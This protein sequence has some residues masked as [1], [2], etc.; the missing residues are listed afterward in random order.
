MS[1]NMELA[2]MYNTHGVSEEQEKVAELEL[3]AKLA[4]EHGV[5]LTQMS[6]EDVASLYADVT[7]G[8]SLKLASDHED[9]DDDDEGEEGEKDE[10]KKAFAYFAEKRAEQEKLAEA[11]LMGRIM[12]HSFTQELENIKEATAMTT[13]VKDL[14]RRATKSGPT[15]SQARTLLKDK[16]KSTAKAGVDDARRTA[17]YQKVQ[18]FARNNKKKLVGGAA[19]AGVGG[20]GLAVHSAMKD[21]EKEVTASAGTFEDL[22][23]ERAVKIAEAADYDANEAAQRVLAVGTLGLGESEKVASVEDF[24]TA[25]HVRGLE[26]LEHAGY[27]VDWSQIYG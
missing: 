19:G 2:Q 8:G 25:L 21:K 5:D 11:D 4:S 26:Y 12:A 1:M 18:N 14:L 16:A 15:G 10:E 22:S 13:T 3:F 7:G 20:A 24:D 23:M 6:D 9:E 27:P 17:G